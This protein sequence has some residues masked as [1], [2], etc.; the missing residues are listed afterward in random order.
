MKNIL[1]SLSFLLLSTVAFSQVW[2]DLGVKGSYG[3]NLLWNKNILD[4]RSYNHKFT[5]S[6]GFG[7]KV[8]I[9][10]GARH[11]FQADV[12]YHNMSQDFTYRLPNILGGEDEYNN[13]V[14]WKTL[15]F[16]LLYRASSNRV[17]VELGPM[18][19]LVRS[20]EQQDDN[21][22]LTDDVNDYYQDN[23]LSGVIG[24]GGFLAGTDIFS[25]NLGFRV[26]YAFQDFITES[27][28]N[29]NPLLNSFPAPVRQNNYDTYKSTN[30]LF[31]E[32]AL[33]FEF[34]L[35]EFAKTS[36]GGRRHFFWSG[37]NR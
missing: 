5:G 29:P 2:I 12:M 17:Y 28:Q 37:N 13:N 9:N 11:G 20:I 16:S 18:Y 31:V 19:S 7:G 14:S 15:D 22:I 27:G 10:F 26:H 1:L 6:S 24:F 4:D 34:G 30:P 35:G 25:I 36:C 32:A 8:G 21:L 23:Y 3:M 33:T